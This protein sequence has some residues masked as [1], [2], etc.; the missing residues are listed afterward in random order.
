MGLK[1]NIDENIEDR[2][3][4][5]DCFNSENAREYIGQRCYFS[6]ELSDFFDLSVCEFGTLTRVYDTPSPFEKGNSAFRFCL[7]EYHAVCK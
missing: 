7:S 1:M 3:Y 6:D 2:K 5:F 4:I